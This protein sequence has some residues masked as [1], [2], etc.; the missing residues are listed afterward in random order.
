MKRIP[1]ARKIDVLCV[2]KNFAPPR[3]SEQSNGIM[4][5]IS[6]GDKVRDFLAMK[7]DSASSVY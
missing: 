6:Q 5:L 1:R 7:A 4:D 2:A 3:I